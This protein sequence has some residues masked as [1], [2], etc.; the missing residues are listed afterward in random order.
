MLLEAI[1][2]NKS[3]LRKLIASIIEPPNT[4]NKNNTAIFISQIKKEEYLV[5]KAQAID[6]KKERATKR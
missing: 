3:K 4:N 5:R 2:N 6:I 1:L